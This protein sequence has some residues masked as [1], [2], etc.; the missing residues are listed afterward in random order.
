MP[1]EAPKAG[2]IDAPV[3]PGFVPPSRFAA[4]LPFV[5]LVGKP[6]PDPGVAKEGKIYTMVA[7][8]NE[9]R[10][11][12][13]IFQATHR[14]GP[15]ERVKD[16][17]GKPLSIF[18]AKQR[19]DWISKEEP[20]RWAPELH[21]VDG[22]WL[23]LY[24]ARHV[25][26]DLRVAVAVADKITGPYRDQG[27][28]L[29][30][31]HGVIDATITQ[32]R[33]TGRHVMIYKNDDNSVGKP[34]PIISRP[35]ELDGESI[36]WLGEGHELCRSGEGHGGLLEGPFVAHEN[37]TSWMLLSSDYYG[38][39]DYKMWIGEVHDLEGGKV[40]NL[41]HLMTTES[42]S[43]RDLW[44]GPGHCSIVKEAPGI[45]GV[46]FH[47]WPAGTE[48]SSQWPKRFEGGEQRRA[49]RCTLAFVDERGKPCKPYIVEDRLKA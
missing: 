1:L 30:A 24:T 27:P 28:I 36:E 23:C 7:T 40:E 13:P 46:Y 41:E 39:P 3:R 29:Q 33:L 6:M 21:N 31:P 47:A 16:T 9:Q 32:D 25:D 17:M 43:L 38:G 10:D 4:R 19:P 48:N 11:T 35:F 20:D 22:K 34:T 37:G 12:F 15:W 8:S 14:D 45:Y 42:P 49:L 18:S 44:K 5:D 2:L 26:G